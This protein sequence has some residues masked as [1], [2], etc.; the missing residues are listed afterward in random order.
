MVS[1][2]KEFSLPANYLKGHGHKFKY[3]LDYYHSGVLLVTVEQVTWQHHNLAVKGPAIETTPTE[4]KEVNDNIRI[5]DDAPITTIKE[6][7]KKQ[8]QA[9]H[10]Q[11]KN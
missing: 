7:E 6:A 9:R 4:E 2:Y 11:S 5:N 10:T 3:W 1:T 8:Q